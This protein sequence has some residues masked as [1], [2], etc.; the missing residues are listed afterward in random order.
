MLVQELSK[1][2]EE[3]SLLTDEKIHVLDN[4]SK[5]NK[6]IHESFDSAESMA[7]TLGMS[8]NVAADILKATHPN[9]Y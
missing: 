1:V 8:I 9:N 3:I 5:T 2:N 4:I 7:N 6:A